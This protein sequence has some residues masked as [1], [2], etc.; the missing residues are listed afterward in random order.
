MKVRTP[1]R[2]AALAAAVL[3]VAAAAGTAVGAGPR[4]G[5]NGDFDLY[6]P[7]TG[8]LL[9]HVVA[10]LSVPTTQRLVAGTHDF[11]GAAG[12]AIL[13]SHGQFAYADFW[14]DPNHPF[15][16]SGGS[17]VAYGEGAECIYFGPNAKECHGGWYVMFVDPIDPSFPNQVVYGNRN[18]AG[19]TT[20][21][22]WSEAG[23]GSFSLRYGGD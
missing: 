15:A 12:N 7:G 16:G 8:Q 2:A 3:L 14:Y 13:E 20:F 17:N 1:H 10:N 18:E 19:E 11:K 4:S 5:F 9:G 23:A 6:D 22:A 21:E